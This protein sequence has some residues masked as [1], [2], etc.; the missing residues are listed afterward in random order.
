MTRR[1]TLVLTVVAVAVLAAGYLVLTRQSDAV[2]R[3]QRPAWTDCSS[4]LQCATVRVPL[5]HDNPEERTLNLGLTRLPARDPAR[6]IGSLLVNFGGPGVSGRESLA[7]NRAMFDRL[8]SRY[9][10]VAFDPR[11]TGRGSPLDCGPDP[12]LNTDPTPDDRR[13]RDALRAA[14]ATLAAGCEKR[15]G[16]LLPYLDTEST[17]RDLDILR[18][19]LGDGRLHYLGFSYGAALGF[20][21]TQLFHEQVGRM[22]LD[23]PPA[24]ADTLI[25]VADMGVEA[26]EKAFAAFLKDCV[27]RADCPLGRDF[28]SAKKKVT[29][30]VSDLDD[31]HAVAGIV[32]HLYSETSWPRLREALSG[33][34]GALIEAGR[35]LRGEHDPTFNQ[36]AYTAITCAD[37]P[38]RPSVDDA[39]VTAEVLSDGSPVFGAWVAWGALSCHGWPRRPEPLWARMPPPITEP[40]LVVG[41]VG[42]PITPF[43]GA[44]D[45]ELMMPGAELVTARG[46]HHTAYG[47]GD[48][49]VDEAVETYLLDGDAPTAVVTC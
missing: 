26:L 32:F 6:R 28:R 33:D 12:L 3:A 22:V 14:Y 35:R 17:A 24:G 16:R 49:C 44:E 41:T 25:A 37:G 27:G 11:G 38:D 10:V 23:G 19:A 31:G 39:G 7:K 40:V 8:S 30:L 42:D 4:G 36:G 5:D 13:E 47:R 2:L 43:S 46:Y 21:Y 48:A 18:S 1:S 20:V 45:L 9:D 34:G 29:Q 15:A